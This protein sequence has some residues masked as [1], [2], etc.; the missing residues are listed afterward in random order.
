MA[1]PHSSIPRRL[2]RRTIRRGLVA[3]LV[4]AIGGLVVN[5]ARGENRDLGSLLDMMRWEYLAVVVFCLGI[6]WMLG[7]YRLYIFGKAIATHT[8]FWDYFRAGLANIFAAG[9]TP[10]STGGGPAQIY[11][12]Q[13]AGVPISVCL[14][15]SVINLLTTLLFFFF[16]ACV[17]LALNPGLYHGN[18][19][20][21][22]QYGFM[23]FG[24]ALVSGS[25]AILKPEWSLRV[26]WGLNRGVTVVSKRLGNA[27]GRLLMRLDTIVHE[28]KSHV[29]DFIV[30]RPG[31]VAKSLVATIA[32]Y[33]NKCLIAYLIVRLMGISTPFWHLLFVQI[34]EF[35]I[36]YFAPTPG[37]GGIAEVSS[38]GLMAAIIPASETAY[39]ALLWRFFTLYLALIVGGVVVMR[40]LSRDLTAEGA[41]KEGE[42]QQ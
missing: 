17:A 24:I 31:I 21:L 30:K 2:N 29:M 4:L 41:A 11:I 26:G 33:C 37:A 34:I 6:D 18:L 15:L 19:N 1:I 9:L 8:S 23:A 27:F 40:Q 3:F 20:A 22:M 42:Y 32:L 36:I 10:S 35:F 5:F 16:G 39:F 7:G 14:A 13:R 12:M 25:V 28:Y 38:S